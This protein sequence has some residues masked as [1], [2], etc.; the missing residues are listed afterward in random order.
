MNQQ[1]EKAML[2]R[3][4]G[5]SYNMIKDRLGISKSTLSCWFKEMPFTPNAT[6]I[7]RIK[8]GPLISG[9]KR[10]NE[11]VRN[12]VKAKKLAKEELGKISK[13]DLWMLGIGLYIGEGAKTY[14]ITRIIN[15]DPK[16]I[17]LAIRWFKDICGLKNDNILCRIHLYPDNDIEECLKYWSRE[18]KVARKN[19][20]KTQV[21]YR[22]NKSG[23]KKRM[24]PYGTAHVTIRSNGNSDFG[25][26]LHR[27]ITGWIE[28]SLTQ[29]EN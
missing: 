23:K 7:K 29:I 18:I 5:Y 2:L 28:S 11:R 1:K 27:R 8:E 20:Q 9:I 26:N 13:R 22:S 21:D 3:K 12:I 6:V 16:V 19:F 17:K 4:K 24:L 25:V 15:S 14:E 10:H